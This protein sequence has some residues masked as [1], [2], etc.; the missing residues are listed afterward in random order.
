MT[1][2]ILVIEDDPPSQEL[3]AYLIEAHGLGVRTAS[4]GDLGVALA[5]KTPPDLVICDIHL[6]GLDGYAVARTLKSDQRLRS[7]PLLAVTA[8]AMVG[9]REKVL[10]EGFDAY[11]TKPIDPSTFVAHI[12]ALLGRASTAPVAPP[13]TTTANGAR[14]PA[15]Q[16][17]LLVVDDSP[18]NRELKRSIFEPHGYRVITAA[19]VSAGL[20]LAQEHRPNLIIADVGLPDGTGLDLLKYLKEDAS[21]Q[22]IPV[23]IITSTHTETTVGDACLALGA[24]RFLI[25]PLD[26]PQILDEIESVLTPRR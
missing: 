6:P 2:T 22:D 19:T 21:V 9:D 12:E 7:I 3:M 11:L 1:A 5:R 8:L 10:A 26:P 13:R 14:P 25:R 17:T 18:V 20:H 15:S 23:V 16:G 24:S 4:R